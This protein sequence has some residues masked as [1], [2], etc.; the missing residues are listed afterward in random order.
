MEGRKADPDDGPLTSVNRRRTLKL[1]GGGAGSFVASQPVSASN[2]Q[3]KENSVRFTQGR[4]TFEGLPTHSIAHNDGFEPYQINH[5][6]K[7]I[8]LKK[9]MGNKNR[10]KVKSE[11]AVIVS[12][13]AVHTFPARIESRK[14]SHLPI[15][16]NSGHL[17]GEY[18]IND[19]L[20][21]PRVRY[22]V[23]DSAISI[24]YQGETYQV[25]KGNEKTFNL[26]SRTVPV[27]TRPDEFIEVDDRR[28]PGETQIVRKRGEVKP[29][30]V[31]MQ[32]RVG[33]YGI[34]DVYD[35]A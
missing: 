24:E 20:R 16:S 14:A 17:A 22:D 23:S 3:E 12:N 18:S 9:G 8:H 35:D 25:A 4:Y 11:K 34:L 15:L 2:N 29:H 13:A 6:D 7:E 10:D 27:R 32:L 21:F 19:T 26:G 31:N 28:R 5:G 1:L 30:E 33:D